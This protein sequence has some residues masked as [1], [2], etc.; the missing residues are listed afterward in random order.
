MQSELHFILRHGSYRTI[1][2]VSFL[3]KICKILSDIADLSTLSKISII[4]KQQQQIQSNHL[5][6]YK[7]SKAA[8]MLRFQN[9]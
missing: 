6:M 4:D 1:N 7:K 3:I 9:S 2:L 8:N 5:S